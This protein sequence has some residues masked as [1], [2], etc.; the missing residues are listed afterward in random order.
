[1]L[2]KY[3]HKLKSFITCY[4]KRIN[5]Y[6]SRLKDVGFLQNKKIHTYGF[7]LLI[8][9]VAVVIYVGMA[10]T[11]VSAY[12][13]VLDNE[14]IGTFLLD[15]DTMS[16]VSK[17]QGVILTEKK[18]SKSEIDPVNLL[19]ESINKK[20]S[21]PAA[22]YEIRIAGYE[23]KKLI[24]STKEEVDKVF[25]SLKDK[26]S[27]IKTY[28]EENV[29][30]IKLA[31]NYTVEPLQEAQPTMTVDEVLRIIQVGTDEKKTYKLQTG[32]SI[33]SIAKKFSL[34]SDSI[35]KANPQIAGRETKLQ[36]GEE[37]SLVVPKPLI[38]VEVYKSAV[39]DHKVPFETKVA[40]TDQ[41][42]KTYWKVTEAGEEGLSKVKAT[43][44]E[45]NGK[46]NPTRTTVLESTVIKEPKSQ[47]A[48]QGT[49]QVPPKKALGTFMNPVYGVTISSR[50][51]Q[52]DRDFHYGIDIPKSIGT[53]VYASDGG[54]I[55]EIE[56]NQYA[57]TGMMIRI[58]HEN[59]YQTKYLHLSAI[60][61]KQGERV[62]Q[63]QRIGSVGNTGISTGPHLHFEVYKNGSPIDPTSILKN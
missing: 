13:V 61:V 22:A 35:L 18:V 48:L 23:G 62:Y 2:D 26:Y 53:A 34:T 25:Q 28:N 21:A 45:E 51:G 24:L 29:T 8:P 44:V 40:L 47:V 31:G 30:E 4:I 27:S 56:Y 37:L 20:P 52:R 60:N 7:A 59:G 36:I 3:I 38:T 5:K 43:F 33:T 12:E 1:M 57:S 11:K 16:D 55:A 9:L 41:E 14:K 17:V 42:Y 15:K 46:I 63:G 6:I 39:Y 58:N 49:L 19:Q 32:D 54:V 10:N 50:F